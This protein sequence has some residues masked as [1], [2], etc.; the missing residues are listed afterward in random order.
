MYSRPAADTAGRQAEPRQGIG[1]G[2]AW[3]ARLRSSRSVSK[4]VVPVAMAPAVTSVA[5]TNPAA[6]GRWCSGDIAL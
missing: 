5:R 2:Y 4:A 3:S 6:P 1:G